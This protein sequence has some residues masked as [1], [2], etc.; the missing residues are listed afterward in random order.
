MAYCVHQSL[1]EF[2]RDEAFVAAKRHDGHPT[3][4]G[5]IVKQRLVATALTA[6]FP[7]HN[8]CT[9]DDRRQVWLNT[10]CSR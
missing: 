4:V 2:N 5:R 8:F 3:T 6:T 9:V 10:F 1:I 7:R